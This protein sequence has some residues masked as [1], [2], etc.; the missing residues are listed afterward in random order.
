MLGR[1]DPADAR[2]RALADVAEQAR[3]ADLPRALEGPGR[4]G[5]D[6]EDP[7]NGV[8]RVPDRPGVRVRPEIP[9]AAALGPAHDLHP[10]ELLVHGDSQVWVALVVAVTDVE[11]G[12]E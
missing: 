5:P 4:A 6:R 2:G 11:P 7:E 9:D 12:V 1:V 8:N 10:W 3:A